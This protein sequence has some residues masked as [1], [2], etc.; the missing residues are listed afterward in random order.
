MKNTTRIASLFAL[1]AAG[2]LVG[3]ASSDR[4]ESTTATNVK[5]DSTC[6]D[7]AGAA[8]ASSCCSE[9]KSAEAKT[10][11]EA[12]TCTESKTCTDTKAKN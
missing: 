8:K 7:S 12:K 3:C 10:C 4:S 11:S 9:G 6:C 2:I 5:S 1:T